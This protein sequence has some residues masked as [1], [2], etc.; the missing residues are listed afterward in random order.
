LSHPYLLFP[1]SSLWSSGIEVRIFRWA[2]F[3]RPSENPYK[4]RTTRFGNGAG[5]A[6]LGLPEGE[7]NE[8]FTLDELIPRYPCKAMW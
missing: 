6:A 2:G 8:R 5:D 3:A 4:F 1:V 7:S